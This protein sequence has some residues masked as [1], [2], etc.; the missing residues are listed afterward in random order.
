MRLQRFV[1]LF[2]LVIPGALGVYGWKLM[3]DALF[4][5]FDTDLGFQWLLF[6]LGLL[7]FLVGVA[8]VGGFIFYRDRKRKL[9]QPRFRNDIDE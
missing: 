7:L 2:I 3:R 5:F 6:L 9:V 8:F 1:A 4:T